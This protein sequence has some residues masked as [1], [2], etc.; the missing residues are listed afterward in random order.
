[1]LFNSLAF[2]LFL[3]LVFF[4]YWGLKRYGFRTQNIFLLIS[5]LFFYGYWDWRFLSLLLLSIFIDFIA[6]KKIE[7]ADSTS[8]KKGW[9]W[10][11][12]MGNLGILLSFKYLDFFIGSFA[13][14]LENLGFSPNITSLNIIFPIG[15]SFYTFQSLGY[16]IDVYRAKAK[17]E[18]N[19][20]TYATYVS[21]FPQLVA[22]PIERAGHLLPQFKRI[23]HF[24]YSE[25]VVGVRMILLGFFKKMVIA[26]GCAKHV[27]YMFEHHNELNGSALLLA[28]FLFSIQIYGDF[29]GYT[30]IAIGTARF[31]GI[32]L[33]K[34]FSYPFFSRN[35]S[36]FW[37]R[38]HISL[39]SWFR[40]YVYIPLG[41]SRYGKQK[42][43]LNILIVFTISGLWHG[44]NWTFV[45]WGLLHGLLYTPLIF[46]NPKSQNSRSII[47]ANKRITL[48]ETL[49]LI[50]TFS[51]VCLLFILFRAQDLG[52]ATAIYSGIA[53]S[54][55]WQEPLYF[56][57]PTVVLALIFLGFEWMKRRET[58][59]AQ[60]IG[61]SWPLVLKILGCAL[62]IALILA[63]S[64]ERQ[65]F[66]YFQF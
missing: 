45:L 25:A 52:Q 13:T 33:N 61:S 19:F 35:L 30:D 42:T 38:W 57:L 34:N 21:F 31:F 26:D 49:G 2:V 56:P 10:F 5:S 43:L 66:I 59:S 17:A 27:D 53:S 65:E 32:K 44:A 20:L 46:F 4:I 23:R 14:L 41:G 60:T 9:L 64:F 40:D 54:S 28:G 3:P 39:S 29:S 6:G 1:M 63:L 16:T 12:L 22:G 15:I 37:R 50:G 24:N 7:Q 47:G 36:E 48:T 55:L 18:S 8:Q 62:V 11:S 58:F 51:I